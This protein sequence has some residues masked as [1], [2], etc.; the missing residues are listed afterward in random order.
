MCGKIIGLNKLFHNG[1]ETLTL[2]LYLE[3]FPKVVDV[4][5]IA[6]STRLQCEAV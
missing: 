3:C 4:Q 1:P 6:K 2:F 5:L